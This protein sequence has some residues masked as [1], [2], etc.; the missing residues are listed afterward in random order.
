MNGTLGAWL[1]FTACAAVIAFA[2][3]KLSRNGDIIADKTGLSGGWIGLVLLAAV[4]SLPELVTGISSVVA[5]D[6]PNIAVG[7]VLGSCV[8]NLTILVLLD[9]LHRGESVYRRASQGHI[10]SAGLG[11]IMIGF[12]GLN[13]LLAG[14]A[15]PALGHVGIY[16]PIIFLLYLVAVRSVY[17]YER[18]QLIAHAAG[19]ASRY[20]QVTLGQA[21]VRYSLAAVAVSVAGTWLPFVGVRLAEIMGWHKTFVGTL[22]VA[23]A[24]SLPELAVMVAALRIRA[25]DMAIASLL[26]SNLFNIAILG[27]DDLFFRRG[28]LL[29]FVSPMQAVSATSA[30][31]MTGIVIV[32]LLYRPRARLLRTAGWAS[33]G[34]LTVY[35]LNT[36]ILYLHGE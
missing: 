22:F 6:A 2:G 34:L 28:P 9:V 17:R 32:A 13:L 33:F 36:W 23:G 20:P 11:V 15:A 8:F 31:V 18:E 4:T 7:D 26:G 16:T 30:V 29:S 19:E 14:S 27:V 10:L 24:T 3:T 21:A 5:A 25:V 12:V 35:L 1:Q